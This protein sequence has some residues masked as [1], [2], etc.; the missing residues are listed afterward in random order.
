MSED[1]PRRHE[2]VYILGLQGTGKTTLMRSMIRQDIL[3]GKGVGVIDPHGDLA[4]A[5]L[6]Y[7]PRERIKDTIYFHPPDSPIGLNLLGAKTVA[8]KLLLS[9]DLFLLFQRL[10]GDDRRGGGV[11]MDAIMKMS[12]ATLLNV[13]GSTF[14]DF[15]RLF[16]DDYFRS[17][18]ISKVTD[19]DVKHFWREVWTTYQHPVTERP[20]VTRLLEFVTNR[21]LKAVTSTLSDLNFTDIVRGKKIF[22]ANIAKGDVGID[23]SPILGTLLV[24]QFQLAGFRQSSLS[25]N[26]RVPFYLFIDEFQNFRTSAFNEII[27]ESRKYRLALTLAN[28]TLEDLR[29]A[30]LQNIASK[31]GTSIFFRL[32]DTDAAKFGKQIGKYTADD[33]QNLPRFHFIMRPGRPADSRRDVLTFPPDPPKGFRS[34]IIEHTRRSYPAIVPLKHEPVPILDPDADPE[35]TP[36]PQD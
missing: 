6:R 16:T 27:I 23:T 26:Q 19:P 14:F 17:E 28:Q 18:T 33:L 4:E 32:M 21:Y 25:E 24:S 5:C 11:Q 30:G 1:V 22:I 31:C 29:E 35:P 36:F 7:I 9:G 8:E 10:V 3:N 15:Y 20:L 12:I 34:E 2:H 13:P